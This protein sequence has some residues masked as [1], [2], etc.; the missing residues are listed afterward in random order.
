MCS[1]R[2]G[3]GRRAEP[4]AV[5]AWADAKAP[6]ERPPKYVVA[7][8]ADGERYSLDGLVLAGQAAPRLVDAQCFD[9]CGGGGTEYA[10]EAPAELART[11]LSLGSQALYRQVLP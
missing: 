3:T 4:A 5:D 11:Q 7:A 1:A 9:K 2:E 10:L 6:L 8:E